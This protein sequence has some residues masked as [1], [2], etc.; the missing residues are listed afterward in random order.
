MQ[1][2]VFFENWLCSF[3]AGMIFRWLVLLVTVFVLT[4]WTWMLF[5]VMFVGRCREFLFFDFL[6][7]SLVFEK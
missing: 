3:G 1:A 6:V 2:L 5:M 4:V 7:Y